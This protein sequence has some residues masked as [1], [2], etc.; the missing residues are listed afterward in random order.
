MLLKT[1][2]ERQ[3][4]RNLPE[5]WWH[6]TLQNEPYSETYFNFPVQ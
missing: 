2:M 4:F 6:Y 1:A 5:E 3:G